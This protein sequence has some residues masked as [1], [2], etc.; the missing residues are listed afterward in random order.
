PVIETSA[1]DFPALYVNLHGETDPATLHTLAQRLK[2][3]LLAQP[4]LSRLQIWGLIPRNLR[5]EVDPERLRQYGLTVADVTGAIQANSL[6]FQAG[7]LRTEGGVVFL[8]ADDRALYAPEYARLPIIERPNGSHVLLGDIATIEDGFLEGDF[9]FRLNGEPTVGMEVLVGQK[10]NL[11]DISRV[12][13]GVVEDFEPQ[14]PANIKASVWGDSAGYISDRLALLRSNGV[15]GLL[16][17]TL[18]LS[19]FLNVRLAFW[20]AMGIPVSVMGAIAVSGSKWV[21]YSLN[22]VTTFGLIIALGILV[23]DA[24]VVGESVFEERG[25]IKDPIKGTERGVERVA[26]ATVFG[27]LTTIAAFYPMLLIDN[28]LGK[29]LAGFSGVVIFALI[30]SLIESKFILP[31]H[32]A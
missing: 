2:E 15:Q 14:L 4:E 5:I 20:V 19:I 31:A 13:R 23:D 22:D 3:D 21:D 29:V 18:M 24:V 25:K 30:F 17:V 6:D 8:R 7:Q 9:L 26:V 27:V 28:P 16:L 10:E 32:L 1:F 12:V 11:L